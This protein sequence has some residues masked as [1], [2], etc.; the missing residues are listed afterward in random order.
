MTEESKRIEY[1]NYL[2]GEKQQPRPKGITAQRL[3]VIKPQILKSNEL[4]FDVIE[5][6]GAASKSA[7]EFYQSTAAGV[8][9]SRSIFWAAVRRVINHSMRDA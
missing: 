1:W 8:A 2:T 7:A 6:Y 5:R 9:D 3:A 4:W